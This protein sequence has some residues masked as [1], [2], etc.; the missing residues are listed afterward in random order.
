MDVD[1][2]E[3]C[4]L[5]GCEV[6]SLAFYDWTEESPPNDYVCDHCRSE[7]SVTDDDDYIVIEDNTDGIDPST[8]ASRCK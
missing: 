6:V 4:P 8:I 7:W 5:C 3:Q 2:T 1:Y